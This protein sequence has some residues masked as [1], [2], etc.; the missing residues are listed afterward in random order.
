MQ[1]T[2]W[3]DVTTTVAVFDD[4]TIYDIDVSSSMYSYRGYDASSLSENHP[5]DLT[6]TVKLS[7]NEVNNVVIR[8]YQ[9]KFQFYDFFDN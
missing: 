1:Y 5:G 8:K 3:T 2:H 4:D 7:K 9:N 6:A